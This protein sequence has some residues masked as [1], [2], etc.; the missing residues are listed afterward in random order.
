[1]KKELKLPDYLIEMKEKALKIMSAESL[2][3]YLFEFLPMT[4]RYPG[5]KKKRYKTIFL[6]VDR[7][8]PALRRKSAEIFLD[9]VEADLKDELETGDRFTYIQLNA[10]FSELDK[11][12]ELLQQ[13]YKNFNL[14][15]EAF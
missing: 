3:E 10:T 6:P 11:V 4:V 8:D 14:L 12:L 9:I 5:D 13:K 15:V 1:M 7:L 2:E